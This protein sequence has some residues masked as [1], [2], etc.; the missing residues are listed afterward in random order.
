MTIILK[1][2]QALYPLSVELL[3]RKDTASDEIESQTRQSKK[4]LCLNAEWFSRQLE[5]R[6]Q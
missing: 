2:L 5:D 6:G 4:L 3:A 1:P